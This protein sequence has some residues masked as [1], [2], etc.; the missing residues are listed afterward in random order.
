M[1]G[2][3]LDMLA[4]TIFDFLEGFFGLLPQMPFTANDL[5]SYLNVEMVSTVMG[6]V[7][8]FLPLDVASSIVALWSTAMMAYVGLKLS[9]KYTGKLI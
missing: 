8:W 2:D 3:F 5:Q 1:I 6:W 9:I 7:N 4:S